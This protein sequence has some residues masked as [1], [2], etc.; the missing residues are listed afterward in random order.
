VSIPV[1]V[2]RMVDLTGV[3]IYGQVSNIMGCPQCRNRQLCGSSEADSPE[4]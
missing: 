1:V 3:T 4:C 2:P